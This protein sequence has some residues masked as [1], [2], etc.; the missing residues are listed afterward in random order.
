MLACA[1]VCGDQKL[2][3]V[4][5]PVTFHPLFLNQ[6]LSLNLELTVWARVAVPGILLSLPPDST[7]LQVHTVTPDFARGS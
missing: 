1:C 3:S 6:A 2:A 7:S 5:V 4:S